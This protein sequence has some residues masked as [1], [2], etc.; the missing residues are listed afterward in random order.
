MEKRIGKPTATLGTGWKFCIG[1]FVVYG[2]VAVFDI[3]VARVSFLNF[4]GMF[5][6][7]LPILGVVFMVMIAVNLYFTP[8]RTQKYLGKESGAT[9]WIYAIVAGIFISGPPYVLYPLLGEMK[10]RGMRNS[11]LAVLLYNR[12]VKIPF[13]PAMIYYFGL[14]FTVFISLYI[15]IFS[16]LNGK[17]IEALAGEK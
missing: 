5:L 7:I 14:K 1:V 13:I 10:K 3:H 12:N 11:L 6:K 8:K 9:G 2:I 15:I 17:L 16:V 4:L